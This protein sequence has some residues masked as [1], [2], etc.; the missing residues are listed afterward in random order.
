MAT[1]VEPDPGASS[2]ASSLPITVN[3]VPVPGNAGEAT[4]CRDCR[5]QY[6]RDPSI[7]EH[8]AAYYRCSRCAK[9]LDS[10]FLEWEVIK[11]TCTIM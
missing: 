9:K 1:A 4:Y 2:G 5:S 10:T 6:V 11:D 3:A 8:V 7:N